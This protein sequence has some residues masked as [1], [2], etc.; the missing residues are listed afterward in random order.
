MRRRGWTPSR[1]GR[2]LLHDVARMAAAS[3]VDALDARTARL[4]PAGVAAL[5]VV[6]AQRAGGV[7]LHASGVAAIWA[8]EVGPVTAKLCKVAM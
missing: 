6:E 7:A 5:G 8:P 4:R 1:A 3:V 2:R